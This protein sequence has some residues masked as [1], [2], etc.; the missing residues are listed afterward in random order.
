VGSVTPCNQFDTPPKC[1]GQSGCFWTS[2]AT[3]V[4]TLTP[5]NQLDSTTCTRQANCTW[6]PGTPT[7][8]GN[9]TPCDQLSP[10][11][12]TL[13]PGCVLSGSP[14]TPISDAGIADAP[15]GDA[16]CSRCDGG[17][18]DLENDPQHCGSCGQPCAGGEICAGGLCLSPAF[19]VLPF[20]V[21]DARY[22]S[23]LDRIVLVSA[24][25]P[26][27]HVYDPAARA[28]RVVPLPTAPTCLSVGPDGRKAA[29]GHNAHVSY[30][31]L[32][33]AVLVGTYPVS[34][35]LGNVVLAGNGIVYG[36]PAGYN[37]NNLRAVDV[38][39]G[40]EH[41]QLGMISEGTLGALHPNGEVVYTAPTNT[42]PSYLAEFQIYDGLPTGLSSQA[43]TFYD[44]DTYGA[45]W[46]TKDG[47]RMFV[48]S[49]QLYTLTV[50]PPQIISSA[51]TYAGSIPG[52]D[53]G[54]SPGGD[55][56]IV[57]VDDAPTRIAALL[58]GFWFP[59]SVNFY[60]PTYL[61]LIDTKPLPSATMDGQP[62]LM[63][64]RWVFFRSDF[65]TVYVVAEASSPHGP[66]F[67][68]A[69]F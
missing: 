63:G 22:S 28:D 51:L 58:R 27:L 56:A 33:A 55:P 5:C 31:D 26:A 40:T 62:A 69:A 9:P 37:W 46:I 34:A 8:A 47:S 35:N 61:N 10:S 38:K 6:T 45:F 14:A 15:A 29:V 7:C 41:A 53:A 36:F 3:C 16:A 17:C 44:S 67:A 64:G 23:A 20:D 32:D 50:T 4:G 66:V 24:S 59:G 30:V 43:M 1:D 13:A 2:T 39:T 48:G 57:W 12:C 21:V 54:Y 49:G 18:F 11:E 60:D 19:D 52:I 65:Q 42:N 25:P 68:V